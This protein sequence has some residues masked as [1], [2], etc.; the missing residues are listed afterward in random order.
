M[1]FR[2]KL[3]DSGHTTVR[4]PLDMWPAFPLKTSPTVGTDVVHGH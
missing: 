2:A 4:I 1:L 3:L